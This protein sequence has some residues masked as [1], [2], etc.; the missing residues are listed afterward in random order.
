MGKK[1]L[2][3]TLDEVELHKKRAQAR[4]NYE[5]VKEL[6]ERCVRL[7]LAEVGGRDDDEDFALYKFTLKSMAY[8]GSVGPDILSLFETFRERLAEREAR[9]Q[10]V[11]DEGQG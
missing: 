9:R 3:E 5:S 11:S 10:G 8:R 1:S 2:E 7:L 6:Y 4:A